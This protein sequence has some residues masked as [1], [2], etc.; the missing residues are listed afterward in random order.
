MTQYSSTFPEAN[1]AM[2]QRFDDVWSP[3]GFPY[4]L[5]NEKF[6]GPENTPWA[7]MVLRHNS[8][9][10]DTLGPNGRRRFDRT[11]SMII[12][13]FT[14]QREGTARSMQLIQ[15]LS[16][17]IEGERI[18]NTTVCFLNSFPREVGPDGKWYQVNYEADFRWTEIK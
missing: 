12:Q 13:V 18:P 10:Q 6:A 16:D 17:G 1:E 8:G 4:V 11:G 15:T 14:P 7:R 3:T 5:G 2:T 9:F